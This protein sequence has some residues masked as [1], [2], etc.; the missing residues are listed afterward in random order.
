M[1]LNIISLIRILVFFLSISGYILYIYKKMKIRIEFIPIIIFSSIICITYLSGLLNIMLYTTYVIFLFGIGLFVFFLV[2]KQLS[3]VFNKN[4]LTT[5]IVFIALSICYLTLILWDARFTF[6]D[7]FTHWGLVVKEMLIYNRLPN[8]LSDVISFKTYPPGSSLFIYYTTKI[9]GTKESKMMI[10]QTFL[11]L[12]CILSMFGII[13]NKKS[14]WLGII[15]ICASIYMMAGDVYSDFNS[16]HVDG[17]LPLAGLSTTAIIFYYRNDIKKASI[18]ASPIMIVTLLLKNSGLFFVVINCIFLLYIAIKDSKTSVNK[19]YTI[20]NFTYVFGV[21]FVVFFMILLWKQHTDYV[22]PGVISKNTMSIENFSIVFN[23]KTSQQIQE[24]ISNFLN[25]LFNIQT[26]PTGTILIA[27]ISTIFLIIIIKLI[28][29]KNMKGMII[30][31]ICINVLFLIY[32][33]GNLCSYIFSIPAGEALRLSAY[34]RYSSSIIIYIIGILVISFIYDYEK[35]FS[36]PDIKISNKK[37]LRIYRFNK[38]L[39]ATMMIVLILIVG[40]TSIL[41]NYKKLFYISKYEDTVP[42]KLNRLVGDNWLGYSN[43]KYLIYSHSK[44]GYVLSVAKYKTYSVEVEVIDTITPKESI[45]TLREYD[46]FVIIDEDE[47]LSIFMSKYID[48]PNY[49]GIY[50]IQE[51]FINDY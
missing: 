23:S 34:Y 29:K 16:L 11:I 25:K 49:Y 26:R 33:T 39:I 50:K 21:I 5:G 43:D 19:K 47:I 38:A 12:A 46:Y 36:A 51:T 48:K 6:Q 28:Y 42:E 9:I 22:F 27:N 24:I 18:L 32:Q 1:V 7:N 8:S 14:Y 4:N 3:I 30:G 2:K 20:Y 37:E 13:K 35:F 41:I 45:K 40:S 15:I 17:L 44:Y 10:A 31:I